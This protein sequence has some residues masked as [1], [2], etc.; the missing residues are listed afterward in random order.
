MELKQICVMK[1]ACI[2]LYGFLQV[3]I[4]KD[5]AIRKIKL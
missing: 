3:E 2:I 4:Q 5:G 1:V